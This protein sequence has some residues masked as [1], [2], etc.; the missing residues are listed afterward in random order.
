MW[1]D[2]L[3]EREGESP[4]LVDAGVKLKKVLSW[5]SLF[6]N[7]LILARL[8]VQCLKLEDGGDQESIIGHGARL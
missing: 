3:C 4:V 8:H 5:H 7:S 1:M 6:V 2:R